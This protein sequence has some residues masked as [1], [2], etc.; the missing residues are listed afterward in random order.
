MSYLCVIYFIL[1]LQTKEVAL[2]VRLIEDGTSMHAV[3]GRFALSLSTVL[4]T[5]RRYQETW[6]GMWED[7]N[8]AAGPLTSPLCKEGLEEHCQSPKVT[9]SRPLMGM[10]LLILAEI[11]SEGGIR[12][13]VDK[14]GRFP[15]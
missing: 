14:C 9:S 12:A 8:P 5:W 10:F 4:R 2:V 15:P 7:N 1:S 13:H 3:V 6:R 11:D